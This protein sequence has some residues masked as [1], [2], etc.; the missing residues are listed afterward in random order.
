[1]ETETDSMFCEF[2]VQALLRGDY[3]SRMDG[4]TKALRM[5]LVSIDELRDIENMNP[6]PDQLGEVHYITL[7]MAPVGTTP[8]P[9]NNIRSEFFGETDERKDQELRKMASLDLLNDMARVYRR[10]GK[11]ATRAAA[12]AGRLQ[13]WLRSDLD[14]EFNPFRPELAGFDD[15]TALLEAKEE[16]R[17]AILSELD[18]EPETLRD[19]VD[20]ITKQLSATKPMELVTAFMENI[21]WNAG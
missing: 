3:N 20:T 9:K 19:R 16:F 5:G 11:N 15:K 1:M 14:E 18:G 17:Q 7:D 2:L 13:E 12:T 4:H 10:I 21:S 6:L 8:E